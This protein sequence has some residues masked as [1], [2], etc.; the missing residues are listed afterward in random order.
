MGGEGMGFPVRALEYRRLGIS[1]LPAVLFR[2]RA[3]GLLKSARSLLI[4][5]AASGVGGDIKRCG[6]WAG[7]G[8]R[9][10]TFFIPSFVVGP[11]PVDSGRPCTFRGRWLVVAVEL[12]AV[13]ESWGSPCG[14]RSGRR[15][16]VVLLVRHYERLLKRRS[17]MR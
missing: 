13:V 6:R 15:R 12:R 7:G 17:R 10:A 16:P 11:C 4:Q 14:G 8:G 9:Q 3:R 2:K 5:E 1:K